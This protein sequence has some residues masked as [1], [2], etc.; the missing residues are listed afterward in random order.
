MFFKKL[1][2]VDEPI[3]KGNTDKKQGYNAISYQKM[4]DNTLI[5]N[6]FKNVG[7]KVDRFIPEFRV[8]QRKNEYLTYIYETKKWS[9]G[10]LARTCNIAWWNQPVI[11][12]E[13][14][15]I[16]VKFLDKWN[17]QS[18]KTS[19]RRI[20]HLQD[21]LMEERRKKKY[22]R[23][24]ESIDKE[25]SKFSDE[26][27]DRARFFLV[28]DI[29]KAENFLFY[30]KKEKLA[31]CTHCEKTSFSIDGMQ[32]K[33]N[34]TVK[35]PMCRTKVTAKSEKISRKYLYTKGTGV[36]FSRSG[37]EL[38]ARYFD[39][40][41]YYGKDYTNPEI[42]IREVVRTIFNKDKIV[43]YEYRNFHQTG[44]RWCRCIPHSNGYYGYYGY[45][46]NATDV[47]YTAND[48][49]GYYGLRRAI[50]NTDYQ[51]S[52]VNL[53]LKYYKAKN[54]WNVENYLE[55]YRKHPIVE[56]FYKI[57]WYEIA[58]YYLENGFT[59]RDY[60]KGV[61]V[62]VLNEDERKMHKILG[63]KKD[64]YDILRK[65]IN[66]SYDLYQCIAQ[67]KTKWVYTK[68]QYQM[69]KNVCKSPRLCRKMFELLETLSFKK[70]IR[71]VCKN[72]VDMYLD[73]IDFCKKLKW[74]LRNTFVAF[75]KDLK[76]AH[77]EAD[78]LIKAEEGKTEIEAINKMLPDIAKKYNFKF[79][80]LIVMA[81]EHAK[82]YI[83][84][85]QALH[86]CISKN[87]MGS[88]ARGECA[89]VFIRT[90]EQPDK[91]YFAMEI[92]DGKIVQVRG[93][94]NC[95]ANKEVS[96]FVDV[97]KKQKLRAA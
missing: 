55:V 80:N 43:N 26:I 85:S 65:T 6:I 84:E 39:V 66:P 68:E 64:Q 9:K 18:D 52:E 47:R 97:F 5:I 41:K 75:P 25:M 56:K 94:D 20:T 73:Y 54:A 31:Y 3:L 16:A 32:L 37:N 8:F 13:T 29:F 79:K 4:D 34:K 61:D 89:I 12:E 27:S 90:I 48:N 81:P 15:H 63:I 14:N 95:S 49:Y 96:E 71:Y 7:D 24:A 40:T 33:H 23:E 45:Y 2:P 51:Y 77:D 35:C 42:T 36:I 82:D 62:N 30:N 17:I 38:L 58:N 86:N 76:A 21:L 22:K 60:S 69:I 67:N 44:I 88:M 93:F 57:G 91:P 92:S 53:F 19:I 87:Y 28:K 50:K 83:T 72:E 46:Y 10:S 11:D 70:V 78:S 1:L 59:K 74:N